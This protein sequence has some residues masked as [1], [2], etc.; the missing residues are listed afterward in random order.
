MFHYGHNSPGPN[1][2]LFNIL[3]SRLATRLQERWKVVPKSKHDAITHSDIFFCTDKHSGCIINT[4]GWVD[5]SGYKSLI[6]VAQSF[7]GALLHSDI[8]QLL[9][10]QWL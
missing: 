3:V 4:C 9:I 1:L 6:H 7:E 5:G 8:I 2:K 10:H